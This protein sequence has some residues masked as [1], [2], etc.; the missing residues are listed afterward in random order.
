MEAGKLTTVVSFFSPSTSLN[1]YR[2]PD[3]ETLIFTTKCYI[4]SQRYDEA[5]RDEISLQ[6]TVDNLTVRSSPSS[7]S[8]KIQDV[9]VI[10][11]DRYRILGIGFYDYSHKFIEMK[12]SKES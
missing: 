1:E 8:I 7:R 2:E 4:K 11:G 3:S 9:A 5:T 12:I 10:S 6:N